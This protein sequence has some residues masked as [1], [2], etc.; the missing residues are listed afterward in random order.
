M[1]NSTVD[2]SIVVPVF[3]GDQSIV[4][5]V[6][7]VRAVLQKS[8]Q[9]FEFIFVH[10]GG[11]NT[12]WTTIASLQAANPKEIRAL[13][14][15][16]NYGQNAATL[17]G[18][19]RARGEWI[20][21][22]DEDLQMPPEEIPALLVKAKKENLELVYGVPE[23]QKQSIIRRVGSSLIKRFFKSIEGIDVGSSFRL[24]SCQL[25]QRIAEP[26]TE[27]VFI[28]QLLSWYT[29]RV[30]FFVVK[31]ESRFVGKSGYRLGELIRIALR[32]V[33]FYSDFLLRL[34]VYFGISTSLVCFGIG[35]YYIHS[36][37]VY[38]A[39]LGF[40]S[41]IVALFFSTGVVVTSISVIGL[42]IKRIFKNQLN[43]PV[44]SIEAELDDC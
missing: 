44:Y 15:A 11:T 4:E 41:L 6:K 18:T 36:K 38:G 22:L 9:T 5:L 21:T 20:C 31:Q 29:D 8:A 1:L 26:S 2:I 32:L 24:I 10:D 16:K 40:T 19:K 28:N 13:K 17:A 43:H 34:M 37:Y 14:L 27:H 35:I 33:L 23:K 30:G 12:S 3:S 25:I 7:R 42:Y 39:E